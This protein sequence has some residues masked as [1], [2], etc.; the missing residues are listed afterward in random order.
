[1]SFLPGQF[2]LFDAKITTRSGNDPEQIDTGR[3]HPN[4]SPA[5][6]TSASR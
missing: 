3:L 6:D 5:A 4:P 2:L 1:M